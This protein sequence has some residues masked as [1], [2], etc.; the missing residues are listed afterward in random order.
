MAATTM[1]GS[2]TVQG[3]LWGVAARDWAEVQEQTA[4]PLHSAALDAAWVARGTRLL[5][6]GCGAGI[7]ALLASL[8][9]ATVSAVDASEGLLDIVRGR[10]PG[11][12]V[13]QADLEALPY[14]DAA[15]DAVIAINSVFYAANPAAALSRMSGVSTSPAGR[16]IRAWSDI[17][18]HR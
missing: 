12:D 17:E 18:E 10:L 7:A 1:T 14:A 15:F 2:G 8:R 5:D 6:A 9:G 3:K 13:R 11:A 16:T 4:L